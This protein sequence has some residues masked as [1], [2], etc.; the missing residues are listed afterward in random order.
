MP[1]LN[2]IY[3]TYRAAGLHIIGIDDNEP[4]PVVLNWNA[5]FHL[6]YNII[7]DNT[8]RLSNLYRVRGLPS[9]Y[10]IGRDGIITQ[11]IYGPVNAATFESTIRDLLRKAS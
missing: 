8:G 11:V 5:Q 3:D 10:V 7:I 9:T 2:S 4:L 1:L 6:D